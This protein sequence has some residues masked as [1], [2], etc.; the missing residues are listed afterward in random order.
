MLQPGQIFRQGRK[1]Y[2]VRHVNASRA[3][4]EEINPRTFVEESTDDDCDT[5]A[6]PDTPGVKQKVKGISIANNSLVQF[7][8]SV[9]KARAAIDQERS[10]VR[11]VRSTKRNEESPMGTVASI[12]VSDK[13]SRQKDSARRAALAGKPKSASGKP[14]TGAAAKAKA[15]A[16]PKAV[17]ELKKCLCGECGDMTAG[18][19]A[20]GHDARFKAKMVKVERGDLAV[21]E[22]PKA[23]QKAYE[24]KKVGAG[25]RTTRNYK[26]ETHQ[27]YDK[28]K[29]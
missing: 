12:P 9:E 28:N 1:V 4:C 3:F 24:F 2:R 27:G 22:L 29:K 13:S 8:E 7:V 14:L 19:F 23:V 11:S 25:F 26:G 5:V 6:D 18:Y 16:R 20:M 10:T 15:N 17:K 21:A